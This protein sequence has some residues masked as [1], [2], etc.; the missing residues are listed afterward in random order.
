MRRRR[1]LHAVPRRLVGQ[2]GGQL[3]Q[4]LGREVLQVVDD[5]ARLVQRG[6]AVPAQLV[7]LPHQVDELGQVAVLPGAGAAA[8]LG[9]LGQD[10]GHPAQLG[11]D[12]APAR[13]GGVRG[14]DRPHGELVQRGPQRGRAQ[15]VGHRGDRAGEPAVVGRPRPQA[16]HPVHLLGDVGEVEVGGERADEHGRRLDGLLGQQGAD[17][18]TGPRLAGLAL[19]G[20]G[21][22]PLHQLQRVGAL[23]AHERLAEQGRD[24]AHVGPQFGITRLAAQQ[25]RGLEVDAH[26][27]HSSG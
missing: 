9:R 3:G 12:R 22:D 11:Q 21:A 19:L 25:V 26:P 23:L 10:V 18:V 5:V 8:R 4:R 2:I 27:P 20:Q 15:L 7:G 16:A 1:Q 24:P 13:L 14:E 17:D 6:R